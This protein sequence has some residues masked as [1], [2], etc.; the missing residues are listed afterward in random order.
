MT[1]LC[2]R[3]SLPPPQHTHRCACGRPNPVV[4][5]L[6]SSSTLTFMLTTPKI[7]FQNRRQNDRR[8]S[9]PLSP[10]EIAALR[11]GGMQILSSDPVT[12]KSSFENADTSPLQSMSQPVPEQGSSSPSP[13]ERADAN[14]SAEEPT[15][16][17][18][19]PQMPREARRE[20][21]PEANV[22]QITSITPPQKEMPTQ[23]PM[24][25]SHSMVQSFSSSVGYLS[26]RWNQGSAF[27]TP[28]TLGRPGDDSFRFVL[29]SS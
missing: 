21:A 14:S 19:T 26:N 4:D 18:E 15:K 5:F 1:S 12:Y 29:I 11:Y 20:V 24:N 13:A 25:P 10:Q 28:S 7:W 17:Q 16:I 8:K 27:A 23:T 3:S 9:R 6:W 2:C 22:G